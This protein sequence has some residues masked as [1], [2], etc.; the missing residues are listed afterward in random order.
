ML[1]LKA[2]IRVLFSSL[3]L[4]PVVLSAQNV[5]LFGDP[6]YVDMGS[7]CSDE[8]GNIMRYLDD[9]GTTYSTISSLSALSGS[10]GSA[11]LLIIPSI[12]NDELHTNLSP[13]VIS[14]LQNFVN[15]GKKILIFGGTIFSTAGSQADDII[16]TIFGMSLS[17]TAGFTSGSTQKNMTDASGTCFESL[18]SDL[19]IIGA[20]HLIESSLPAGSACYFKRT[21]GPS[22]EV[23]LATIPYG[24]GEVFYFGWDYN[25]GGPGCSQENADWNGALSCYIS[26]S[27]PADVPDP[28][29][30][31]SQWGLIILGLSILTMGMVAVRQRFVVVLN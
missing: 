6:T 23:S 10:L 25:E 24:L 30:T 5:L 27:R 18:P 19:A 2:Q 22:S 21:V 8:G 3:L 1:N 20:T 14:D 17:T 15:S 9:E 11:D 26:M 28:I 12:A 13:A 31:L 4:L 16:N 29:P 7:G